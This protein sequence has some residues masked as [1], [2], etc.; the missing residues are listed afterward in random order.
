MFLILVDCVEGNFRN[1][2]PINDKLGLTVI[3]LSVFKVDKIVQLFVVQIN[4]PSP[5]LVPRSSPV[6]LSSTRTIC[7][8][9]LKNVN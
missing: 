4:F 9:P 2:I 1:L 6:D 3:Y 7:Q 8:A 5:P